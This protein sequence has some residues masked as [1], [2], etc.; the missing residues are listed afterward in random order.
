MGYNESYNENCDKLANLD[1][2]EGFVGFDSLS[3]F[4]NPIVRAEYNEYLDSFED[5]NDIFEEDEEDD[6]YDAPDYEFGVE[7]DGQPDEY[8]EWQDYMGGDDSPYDRESDC[9]NEW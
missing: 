1:S 9:E 7:D 8:T 3:E 2:R 5:V 6:D 4:D